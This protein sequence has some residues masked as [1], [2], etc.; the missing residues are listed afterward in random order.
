MKKLAGWLLVMVLS[1]M[2]T[3]C[4]DET[5]KDDG[6]I[7]V[8]LVTGLGGLGDRSFSDSAWEGFKQAESELGV[9]IKV[10]EPQSVADYQTTISSVA[11]AGYDLIMGVGADQYDALEMC[12]GQYPDTKFAAVNLG[13]EADNLQVAK[14]ADHEGAFLAGA[15][16]GMFTKTGVI[17]FI[18]G[19]DSPAIN[20]FYVGYEEG[21]KYVNPDVKVISSYV[22]SFSDPGKGKE[23]AVQLIS[24]DADVIFHASGKTGEGLFEAVKEYEDVYAIG[25][26]QNQDYIVKGKILTSMEKR[27]NVAAY[28]MIKSVVEGSFQPGFKAYGVVENGVGL[29]EM[30]Y[31][32]DLIGEDILSRLEQIRNDIIAGSIEITDVFTKQ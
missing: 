9:V 17:G 7:K 15:L 14:F 2:L 3:G 29:T 27:V 13:L 24:Q 1:V 20:R 32:K 11:S 28:D 10:V 26:D 31:T 23:F 19:A 22:G 16:A 6:V 25:V 5:H 18:G 12:S 30:E 21:A 4:A 8:A